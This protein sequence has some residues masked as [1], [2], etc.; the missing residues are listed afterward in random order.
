MLS[1]VGMEVSAEKQEAVFN[2]FC[3]NLRA[4]CLQDHSVLVGCVWLSCD[5]MEL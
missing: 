5:P 3:D 1:K 2:P 4:L